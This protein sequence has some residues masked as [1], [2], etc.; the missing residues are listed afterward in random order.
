M[1]SYSSSLEKYLTK[2]LGS[3]LVVCRWKLLLALSLP[4]SL[5]WG[6]STACQEVRS[7]VVVLQKKRKE[8]KHLSNQNPSEWCCMLIRISNT[9]KV[10]NLSRAFKA[11]QGIPHY[12]LEF[13]LRNPSSHITVL[14][15]ITNNLCQYYWTLSL[16]LSLSLSEFLFFISFLPLALIIWPRLPLKKVAQIMRDPMKNIQSWNSR[17]GFSFRRRRTSFEL[18]LIT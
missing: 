7:V 15:G 9:F 13:S 11:S 6:V 2:V 18:F 4:M 1:S 10:F 8:K 5:T 3:N 16:S 14:E 17:V 12:T